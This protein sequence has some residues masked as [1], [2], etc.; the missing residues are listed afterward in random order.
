MISVSI[1]GKHGD[2][3]YVCSV[4]DAKNVTP[5]ELHESPFWPDHVGDALLIMLEHYRREHLG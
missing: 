5:I 3:W 4:C 2:I 1:E